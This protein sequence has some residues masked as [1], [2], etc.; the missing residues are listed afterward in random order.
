MTRARRRSSAAV[1]LAMVV[2]VTVALGA[3]T[4][5]TA[6]DTASAPTTTESSPSSEPTTS[7]S[8]PPSERQLIEPSGDPAFDE[9]LEELARFVEVERGLQF[10]KPV[11]VQLLDDVPFEQRIIDDFDTE[12][13]G[14]TEVYGRI[15]QA[16]GLVPPGTDVV[17]ALRQVIGEGVLGF[18]DPETDELV[19][20]GAR[21]SPYVRQT[22]VHELVHAIDDQHFDLDR[23][24]YDDTDD[25]V[26]FGFS[27]LAEGN[28]SHVEDAWTAGLSSEERQ[29]LR[30]EEAQFGADIYQGIPQIVL[31]S[32]GAPYEL[33]P[34]FVDAILDAGG[35]R[36]LDGAF[37]VP[38]TT[39]EQVLHPERYLDGEATLPV[40]TPPADGVVI[41]DGMFGEFSLVLL[42]SGV[43]GS[44]PA[45]ESADGWGGDQ[46]V[47]WDTG[48]GATCVRADFAMDTDADRRELVEGLRQWAGSQ[49]GAS[50][51]ELPGGLT[52]LTS[53]A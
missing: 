40:A 48:T 11:R 7:T 47:A 8:A 38:P 15:L 36:E 3:C 34:S 17:G 26:S 43:I 44:R 41:D 9:A 49:P 39:S 46:Y 33:G 31:V 28:A 37:G 30:R 18:Y 10:T 51:D 23:P 1:A 5:R 32:V 19:V 53:C 12:D 25:E 21:L 4:R 22:I 16:L 2:L 52:R 13:R 6:P 20:R 14:E 29:A 27:V 35:Q 42:L 50:V 45:N 24:P